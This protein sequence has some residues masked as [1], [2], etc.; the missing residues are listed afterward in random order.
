MIVPAQLSLSHMLRDVGTNPGQL[1]ECHHFRNSF[2]STYS[3]QREFVS[4]F[5]TPLTFID[6]WY[7]LFNTGLFTFVLRM[8]TAY[9][10]GRPI[11]DCKFKF[12]FSTPFGTPLLR[13]TLVNFLIKL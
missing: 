8:S 4:Y 7:S 10:R 12:N 13:R 9:L 5:T 2:F 6:L 1:L 3:L 11:F